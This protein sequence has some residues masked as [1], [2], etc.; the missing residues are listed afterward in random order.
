MLDDRVGNPSSLGG[1]QHLCLRDPQLVDGADEGTGPHRRPDGENT[2]ADRASL[3]LGDEDRRGWNEE[4]AAQ[5]I[6]VVTPAA[7]VVIVRKHADDGI[8]I[9][10]TGAADVYL[11][12]GL[13]GSGSQT[14]ML[15]DDP[16]ED[17]TPRRE[18]L[19]L[20][21]STLSTVTQTIA[22]PERAPL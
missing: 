4:Q 11:H 16:P 18:L 17:S 14:G 22:P 8:Q 9:G 12:V 10:Q 15:R 20:E 3:D 21:S 2:N 1:I 13:I 7:L 5:V 19:E 6:D